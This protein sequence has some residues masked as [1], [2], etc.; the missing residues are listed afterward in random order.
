MNRSC[1]DDKRLK[2]KSWEV[3]LLEKN[4]NFTEKKDIRTR[5]YTLCLFSFFLE[6]LHMSVSPKPPHIAVTLIGR[7]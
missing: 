7:L 4:A 3:V 6:T 2:G 1:M 5:Y